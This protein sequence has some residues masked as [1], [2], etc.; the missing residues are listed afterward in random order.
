MQKSIAQR[1]FKTGDSLDDVT[2]GEI[3][4]VGDSGASFV[5]HPDG[6]FGYTLP[7]INTVGIR[8]IADVVEHRINTIVGSRLHM[9]R[10]VNGGTLTYA[11]NDAGDLVELTSS[12]LVAEISIDN[13]IVYYVL[14]EPSSD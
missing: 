6:S 12:N 3:V 4:Q 10:F 8:D 7:E 1:I 2:P 11:Y 5:L 14:H 9:V 13:E